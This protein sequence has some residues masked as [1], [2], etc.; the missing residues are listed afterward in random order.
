LA[1]T[2]D[3]LG[4]SNNMMVDRGNNPVEKHT[5]FAALFHQVASQLVKILVVIVVA[6]ST[7]Q[8]IMYFLILKFQCLNSEFRL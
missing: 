4:D 3:E 2:Q 1:L 7:F 6:M 5:D 8:L